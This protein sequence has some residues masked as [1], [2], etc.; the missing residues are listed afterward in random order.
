MHAMIDDY[1]RARRAFANT[2][3]GQWA[4]RWVD[5]DEWEPVDGLHNSEQSARAA[6]RSMYNVRDSDFVV[7][8][9]DC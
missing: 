2:L 4:F 7:D 3:T 1:V 5:C 6:I 8:P 9:L